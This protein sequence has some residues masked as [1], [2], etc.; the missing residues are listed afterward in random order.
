MSDRIDEFWR[1]QDQ[2]SVNELQREANYWR[3]RELELIEMAPMPPFVR[4]PWYQRWWW[5]LRAWWRGKPLARH[6]RETP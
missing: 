5:Y 2:A 1:K 3:S 4:L 6:R